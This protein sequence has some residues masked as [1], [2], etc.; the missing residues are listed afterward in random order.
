[1]RHARSCPTNKCLI[2]SLEQNESSFSEEIMRHIGIPPN[3]AC[4]I[5]SSERNQEACRILPSVAL[6][7]DEYRAV[8][9]GLI[10]QSGHVQRDV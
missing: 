5:I 10:I 3:N 1:M 2:R 8:D 7:E 6:V 9:E 4:L